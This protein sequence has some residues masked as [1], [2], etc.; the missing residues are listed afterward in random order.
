MKSFAEFKQRL[1]VAYRAYYQEPLDWALQQ[2]K[3]RAWLWSDLDTRRRVQAMGINVVPAH[4]YC[5]VP[6]IA[7]IEGSFEYQDQDEPPYTLNVDDAELRRELEALSAYAA[8]FEPAKL[9]E[10]LRQRG[11]PWDGK[12]FGY[13]DAMAYYCY[14]RK[15]KPRTLVEVGSGFS[16]QVALQALR[17]NGGGQVI[18]IEPFPRQTLREQQGIEL[19][20]KPAQAI[21]AAFLNGVL[22]DGDV[23][24][25]DSTHTVKSGSDCLHLY[26]RLL[27]ALQRRVHVHVHDIYLPFGLPKDWLLHKQT[28][29]TE[30]YL[31]LAMLQDNPRATIRYG[32][33]YHRWR[34][35]EL[36]ERFMGGKGEA[37][38]S[39]FWFEYRPAAPVNG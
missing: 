25:I 7:E 33:Y 34:N 16:T 29:W 13:A 19:V 1:Q 23:V 17:N 28:F 14:L 24:F 37:F 31:L 2:V 5:D 35:R 20:Q 38:G 9:S 21:D 8:E 32:S 39:S 15:L 4:F 26:L 11:D 3:P 18:C 27:P 22:A 10:E 6:T 12:M 36:F 30:Q